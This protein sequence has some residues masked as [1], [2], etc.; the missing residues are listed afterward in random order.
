MKLIVLLFLA[1]I[2]TAQSYTYHFDVKLSDLGHDMD[3]TD[4]SGVKC[5]IDIN[6]YSSHE[7]KMT[8]NIKYNS[9]TNKIALQNVRSF[10]IIEWQFDRN[11]NSIGLRGFS[12]ERKGLTTLFVG[13]IDFN[14][15]SLHIIEFR[16][17]RKIFYDSH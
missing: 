12:E 5:Y 6:L 8:I 3:T 7:G 1:A 13:H 15:M 14:N 16:E 11:V 17:K 9:D 10:D 4:F 2:S